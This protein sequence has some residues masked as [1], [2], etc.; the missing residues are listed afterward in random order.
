[1]KMD[2]K[3]R[4]LKTGEER[5]YPEAVFNNI[6]DDTENP[7]QFIEYVDL[8]QDN[9]PFYTPPSPQIEQQSSTHQ[10][11]L[12]DALLNERKEKQELQARI[13]ELESANEPKDAPKRGRPAKKEAA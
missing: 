9:Q 12:V 5:I 2:V 10:Q 6:C 3:A 13:K 7:L 8:P 1:M 4:I 11:I